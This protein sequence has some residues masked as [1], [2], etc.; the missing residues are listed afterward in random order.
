[1]LIAIFR[2]FDDAPHAVPTLQELTS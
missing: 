1:L 2:P